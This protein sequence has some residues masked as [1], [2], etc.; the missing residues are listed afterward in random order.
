MPCWVDESFIGHVASHVRHKGSPLGGNDGSRCRLGSD[1][2]LLVSIL[3]VLLGLANTAVGGLVNAPCHVVVAP[4]ELLASDLF[5]LGFVA[6]EGNFLPGLILLLSS[7]V[8]S[9]LLVSTFLFMFAI[10]TLVILAMALARSLLQVWP[11]CKLAFEG[12]QFCLHCNDLFLVSG[13][14][15]PAAILLEE[16]EL[17]GGKQDERF[18]GDGE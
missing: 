3:V 17:V 18:V 12:C 10:L 11:K 13:L 2:F 5:L 9:I 1:L 8:G 7:S 16:I 6:L 14:C 4:V 15:A